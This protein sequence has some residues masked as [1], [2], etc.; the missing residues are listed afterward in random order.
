MRQT[1]RS[2]A[3]IRAQHPEYKARLKSALLKHDAEKRAMEKRHELEL[4]ALERVFGS[5]DV[6]G[7]KD[8]LH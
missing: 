4:Q 1:Y 6:L 3:N 8:K 7:E 5:H 2:K